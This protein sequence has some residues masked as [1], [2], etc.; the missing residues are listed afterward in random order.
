MNKTAIILVN[1]GT[2]DEPTVKAVR[3]YLFQFLNDRRVIDLPLIPQKL[4]VNLIIVPFR[5]PKSTKLYQQLWTDKGSPLLYNALELQ[6]KLQKKTEGKADV[7]IAMRYQNPSIRKATEAIKKAGYSKVVVLPMFPQYASSTNGTATQAVWD[8][9]RHWNTLPDVHV[10]N[11]FWHHAAFL[12]A[13]AKKI[14]S[15][16]PA[17][18]DHLIF[19]YHGLPNRQLD[20]THPG[21]SNQTCTCEQAMPEHGKFCYKATCYET[22]RQLVKRLGLKEGSY[23]TSFQSRLSNNW[24]K[25][26]TDKNLMSRAE[27][28]ATKLLVAAPSFVADCLETTV[29][30]GVEY[31]ELFKQ[32][33]GRNLTMVESLNADDEWVLAIERIIEPYIN[34]CGSELVTNRKT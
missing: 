3:R 29:E 6:E 7:F 26:F 24:M 27:A 2:P 10:I 20:K 4:L 31:K 18:Y 17:E 19:T 12:D 13:F 11:Q 21:I 32:K 23:S 5:A 33:G 30:I 25:P 1:V 14:A 15:Y 16:N 22:T 28:G 9:L 8:E 34:N